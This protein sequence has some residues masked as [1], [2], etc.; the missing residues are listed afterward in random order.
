MPIEIKI[1]ILLQKL[2]DHQKEPKPTSQRLL[3]SLEINKSI[4]CGFFDGA[5]Q[6]G[7]PLGRVDGV[8]YLNDKEKSEFLFPP[9]QASNSKEKLVAL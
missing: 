8:L 9:E 7:P 6:G 2:M 1:A 3:A 5:S 4:P